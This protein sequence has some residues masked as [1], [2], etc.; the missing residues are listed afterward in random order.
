LLPGALR[1]GLRQ[2][3]TLLRLRLLPLLLLLLRT[4]LLLG[5]LRTLL[6]LLLNALLLGFLRTLLLLLR[7]LGALLRFGLSSARRLLLRLLRLRTLRRL[8]LY[9]LLRPFARDL[10]LHLRVVRARTRHLIAALRRRRAGR[11]RWCFAARFLSLLRSGLRLRGGLSFARHGLPVIL[12]SRLFGIFLSVEGQCQAEDYQ[13]DSS[14]RLHRKG[15]F[16]G[17]SPASFSLAGAYV[18]GRAVGDLGALA[19]H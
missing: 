16:A 2:D 10:P 12:R 14:K 5:F 4:L 8:R 15:S 11:L 7:L 6:L 9:L 17:V 19:F 18:C 1:L 3:R 13:R